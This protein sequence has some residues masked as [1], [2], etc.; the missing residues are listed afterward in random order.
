[1][2]ACVD[3]ADAVLASLRSR[4]WR[5]AITGRAG[6]SNHGC[7]AGRRPDAC[8]E[9]LEHAAAMVLRYSRSVSVSGGTGP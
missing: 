4:S 9:D 1:M 8:R 3:Q 7:L 6:L 5:L 2:K